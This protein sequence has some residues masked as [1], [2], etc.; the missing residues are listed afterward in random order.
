MTSELIPFGKYKGQPVEQLQHDEQYAGWL[1]QQPWFKERYGK[2]HTLIVN[3]FK[4]ESASPE[5]NRMQVR[6]LNKE[7]CLKFALSSL[8]EGMVEDAEELSVITCGTNIEDYRERFNPEPWQYKKWLAVQFE[9]YGWDVVLSVRKC[10]PYLKISNY[11][12][13]DGVVKKEKL[14]THDCNF[15]FFIE[16]KP[17]IGDD[18]PAVLR[19]VKSRAMR[20]NFPVRETLSSK[21]IVFVV[22]DSFQSDSVSLEDA[23][24][25]FAASRIYLMLSSEVQDNPMYF[26]AFKDL[27]NSE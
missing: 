3:N 27:L 2:I 21:N 11:E 13:C 16:L 14:F 19:Q 24:S 22:C 9:D 17:T 8:G 23:K 20:C 25:M 26:D 6:F 10:Y 15:C 18:F 1:V 12:S 7:F 4:E 5:H